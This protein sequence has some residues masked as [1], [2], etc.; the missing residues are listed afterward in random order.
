MHLREFGRVG[1]GR[2]L[3]S[4]FL[5]FDVSFMVWV[6]LGALGSFIADDLG[7]NATEKGL[8]TAVPLLAGS[9]FR[10]ILGPLAD[11]IGGRRA[12]LIG[13]TLTTLPLL[14][15][16]LLADSLSGVIAVGILLGVAGASFAVALPLASRWYPPEHQGLAL[17]IA[18][19]GN[20]GTVIAALIA[21]RL[22][23]RIGWQPVLGLALI[24]VAVTFVIF[25]LLA[26]DSPNHPPAPSFAR[27]LWGLRRPETIWLCLL[28]AVT[29]GG[30]VG[31]SSYLAIFFRDQYGVSRVQAG[32]LTGACVFAGSLLR[33]VGGA[34]S[35]RLGGVRVLTLLL[36]M[37]SLQAAA[38]SLLPPLWLLLPILVVTMAT[39]GMGNG[40]VFQIIPGVF[41]AELGVIT[42]LVGAAGGIGGFY[43]PFVLGSLKGATGS[44]APGFLA[45]SAMAVTATAL[46]LIA[47][48]R[49][50]TAAGAHPAAEVALAH[51][52]AAIPQPT[53]IAETAS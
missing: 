40:A 42:G 5:Y 22:A 9:G 49:L 47:Q 2:V 29:F 43:L 53:G 18:G 1:N 31:L 17:G 24:P 16:W 23:E 30:F 39:L 44:F 13:L 6:L 37:I 38:I 3:F 12:G 4:S 36:G 21:P 33:P 10:L 45:F 14:F 25:A 35:D 20:S 41:R 52:A 26:H 8:I 51:T 7:L 11:H 34:L 28:Y 15:G 50:R 27:Y 46:L 32:D 19:A 48:S